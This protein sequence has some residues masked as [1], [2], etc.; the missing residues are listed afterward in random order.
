[1]T[2]AKQQ[3]EAEMERLNSKYN[4]DCFS[5][6]ELDLESDEGEQYHYEHGYQTLIKMNNIC[7]FVKLIL[8]I[9]SLLKTNLPI[10]SLR[11]K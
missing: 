1:M 11:Y 7:K 9:T 5:D 4:L 6:S 10:I 3:W 8:G 2:K